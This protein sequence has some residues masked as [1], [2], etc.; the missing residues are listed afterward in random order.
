MSYVCSGDDTVSLVNIG[1]VRSVISVLGMIRWEGFLIC[2]TGV[3]ENDSILT[4]VVTSRPVFKI[5]Y[6][7]YNINN[8]KMYEGII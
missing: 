3:C 5:M 8:L 1:D 2:Y 6:Q 4:S 7:Y